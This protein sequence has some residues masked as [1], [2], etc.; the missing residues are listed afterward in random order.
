[1]ATMAMATFSWRSLEIILS[2]V[3]VTNPEGSQIDSDSSYSCWL[4]YL[5]PLDFS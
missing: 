2:D 1:M 5:P 4:L 3:G